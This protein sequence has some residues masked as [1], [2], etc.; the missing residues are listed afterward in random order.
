MLNMLSEASEGSILTTLG[1]YIGD[2]FTLVGEV[3]NGVW[4][5]PM[6]IGKISIACSFLGLAIGLYYRFI[7]RH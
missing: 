6:D 5:L 4:G 3:F 7:K 2:L 1:G